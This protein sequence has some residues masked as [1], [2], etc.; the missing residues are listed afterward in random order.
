M[1]RALPLAAFFTL[2]SGCTV[3]PLVPRT[4]MQAMR[5]AASSVERADTVMILLPGVKDRASVFQAKGFLTIVRRHKLRVDLIAADAHAG[6]YTSGTLM[7][8]LHDDIIEPARR[9]GYRHIILVGVSMGG[10]GAIRYAETHPHEISLVVALSPF[11]GAG[12]IWH[13]LADVGDEGFV[14]TWKW[15]AGYPSD[16]QHTDHPPLLLGYGREDT[17]LKTD[18]EL[19][20][21]LPPQAVVTAFGGHVWG[22]WRKLFNELLDK[23]MIQVDESATEVNRPS[24]G[25]L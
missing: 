10:Y 19:K 11:L 22:T 13:Q 3:P 21:L 2:M 1:I 23:R 25:R 8:R 4:P 15:L 17:L 24:P 16:G 5:R 7:R 9:R 14:Q 18:N 12:T 20:E 6:Y